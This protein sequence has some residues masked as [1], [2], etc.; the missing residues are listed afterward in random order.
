LRIIFPACNLPWISLDSEFSLNQFSSAALPCVFLRY[1]C[2]SCT[3]F[4]SYRNSCSFIWMRRTNTSRYDCSKVRFLF[5]RFRVQCNAIQIITL[6][7]KYE[8]Y[9]WWTDIVSNFEH[10]ERYRINISQ[11]KVII[12]KQYQINYAFQKFSFDFHI[13]NIYI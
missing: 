3:S 8:E 12:L 13:F 7:K 4:C 9:Y 5:S 10:H 1:A 2:A 6:W 11:N